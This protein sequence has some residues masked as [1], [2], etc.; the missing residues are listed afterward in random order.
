MI[1][2]IKDFYVRVRRA[3]LHASCN[4]GYPWTN[5]TNLDEWRETASRKLDV[6]AEIILWHQEIDDRQP[7]HIVDDKLIPSSLEPSNAAIVTG[8]TNTTLCDK[9]LVYCAFPSSYTQVTKVLNYY[10]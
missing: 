10:Y 7:L 2:F 9:I 1:N 5:P 8:V 3:L 4:V 6:L